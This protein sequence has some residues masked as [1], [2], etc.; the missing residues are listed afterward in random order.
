MEENRK[1]KGSA[2]D[3]GPCVGAFSVFKQELSSLDWG[4]VVR[5][6]LFALV[7]GI[8]GA[9]GSIVLCVVVDA[10]NRFALSHSF[11]LFALPI[12]GVL[13]LGLYHVLKI[14]LDESTEDV[15]RLFRENEPVSAKLAPGIL[16]GTA[17]TVLGGGSVGKEAG[18]LQ[19]G[20]SLGALVSRP[21]DLQPL[22]RGKRGRLNGYAAACGMASCFSAL[23][24]SPLGATMFVLELSRF[25]RT[26]VC[27]LPTMLV[28]AFVGCIIARLVG[29]GDLIPAVVVPDLSVEL[30][31]GCV[32]VGLACGVAGTVFSL[33]IKGAKRLLRKKVRNPYLAVLAGGLLFAGLVL[34]FGWY[35]YMGTGGGLMDRALAGDAA[36]WDFAVKLLLTVIALG[37]GFKGGEIMPMFCIGSLLGC[38]LGG[39]LGIDATLMAAVGLVGFFAA[40]SRCPLAA[41]LIGC[42]VF[43]W[44]AAPY[45]AV[46]VGVAF[47]C[48]ADAGYYGHG[49][50]RGIVRLKNKRCS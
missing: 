35:D 39:A 33:G 26:V 2:L 30:L 4:Q 25:D 49:A 42:E 27:R 21:F 45:L 9:V 12:L 17:L 5:H 6:G 34:G 47:L 19:M 11:V 1:A 18:A 16:A 8:A 20:A 22:R 31:G 23:F 44:L 36:G 13:G 28:G 43:G 38:A 41:F 7:V 40:A 37:F 14:P 29:I 24:F 48:G 3:D 15:V 10:A 50:F 32:L 46:S